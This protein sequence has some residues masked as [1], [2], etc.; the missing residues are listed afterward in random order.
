[1]DIVVGTGRITFLLS[2]V[3]TIC[4]LAAWIIYLTTEDDFWGYTDGLYGLQ[5]YM[6]EQY[7]KNVLTLI[8]IT[9]FILLSRQQ[10][11]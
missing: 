5:R 3:A 4:Y 10:L 7:R 1:M 6:F 11:I 9:R 2:F 8:L